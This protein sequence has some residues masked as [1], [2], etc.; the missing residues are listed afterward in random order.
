M[1]RIAG[2]PKFHALV[3]VPNL[4]T[5]M[6]TP[7]LSQSKRTLLR[8]RLVSRQEPRLILRCCCAA[9]AVSC[10]ASVWIALRRTALPMHIEASSTPT[11]EA[12][13]VQVQR[14][15]ETYSRL[16]L[17]SPPRTVHVS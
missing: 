14:T 10:F 11:L 3:C 17:L 12:T 6:H 16:A 8:G 13:L 7:A 4:V 15:P 2:S 9:V 5:T 1:E